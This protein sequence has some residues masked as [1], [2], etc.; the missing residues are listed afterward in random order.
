MS[1]QLV[2]AGSYHALIH[3]LKTEGEWCYLHATLLPDGERV[4]LRIFDNQIRRLMIALMHQPNLPV[5]REGGQVR[6]E[7]GL[8]P[9]FNNYLA[10]IER[11]H[12][13]LPVESDVKLERQLQYSEFEN[14]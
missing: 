5:S 3:G 1:N 11:V 2:P 13:L 10:G 8:H 9:K 7:I 12:V 4:R 14:L 6:L